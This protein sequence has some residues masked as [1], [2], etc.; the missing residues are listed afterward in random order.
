MEYQQILDDLFS[1]PNRAH[2][3][4]L[5]Y[6]RTLCALLGNPQDSLRFVH[7]AG[8]NG[9][10]STTSMIASVLRAGGYRTGLFLSP[11]I[12]DFRERI[13]VNG[14][15]IPK[16]KLVS[17][18]ESI[19][20]VVTALENQGIHLSHFEIVTAVAFLYWKEERCD[21]VC[22]ETGIG[23][24]YDCTNIIAPPLAAVITPV[25]FDHTEI[26]GDTLEEIAAQKAG[27]I[28]TG[29]VLVS[30]PGQL[31]E[32]SAVLLQQCAEAGIR[33][34][35][36]NRNAVEIQ[37]ESLRGST[38][39]YG[40]STF[41]ISL[42][43]RHQIDNALTAMETIH[44]LKERGFPVTTENL[45]RGLATVRFPIRMELFEGEPDVLVDGA[46][47]PGGAAVLA[48][49]L[50]RYAPERR[51][52]ALLGMVRGKETDSFFEQI[53]PLCSEIIAVPIDNPRGIPPEELAAEVIKFCSAVSVETEYVKALFRAKEK[54]GKN[55]L[56]LVA[57]SL[58]LGSAIRP[59][60][61]RN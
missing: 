11:F 15:M 55:G 4:D 58:F 38:F 1:R 21:V 8:T 56:I 61:S 37:S 2:G 49:A 59:L 23:G 24:A 28:K 22:L 48:D 35:T 16:E 17:L 41:T 3:P 33:M 29:S 26:L 42:A 51:I 46:H 53:A 20:L 12:L 36:P 54:A 44:T 5:S 31:P 14:E 18:V 57:G 30:S 45:Q 39:T 13:Q 7:V 6:F 9:K 27:I 10:G 19:W 25:S 50:R 60:V 32:V 52:V 43:G 47:N 40:G 34:I